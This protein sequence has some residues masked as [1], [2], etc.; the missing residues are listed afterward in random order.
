[1]PVLHETTFADFV[2]TRSP[3]LLYLAY[4]LTRDRGKAEDLL[5]TALAR[6]WPAWD[7]IHSDPEAYVRRIMITTYSAWWRRKW[8]GEVPTDQLPERITADPHSGVDDREEMLAALRRLPRQQRA[9]LVLRYYED[10]SEVDIAEI[11]GISPGTVKSHAQKALASLRLD[12]ALAA[13]TLRPT[14][15]VAPI[16]MSAVTLRVAQR[17]RRRITAIAAACAV[18]TAI[19]LG[20][21]LNPH[22]RTAPPTDPSPRPQ[23]TA[24]YPFA[25]Y[26]SGTRTLDVQE[27][28]PGRTITFRWPPN[29]QK[30]VVLFRCGSEPRLILRLRLRL[31][32]GEPWEDGACSSISAA[33]VGAVITPERQSQAG[34]RPGVPAE[35]SVALSPTA[36]DGSV[37]DPSKRATP[38]PPNSQVTVGFA[39]AV[40]WEEYV[41]PP[42]QALPSLDPVLARMWSK[43]FIASAG[44][45]MQP[46]SATFV[47]SE[48]DLVMVRVGAPVELSVLVAGRP[49]TTCT[50][51][52]N[53]EIAC[54]FDLGPKSR[55]RPGG[56]AP[57]LGSTVTVTVVPVHATEPW[58]LYLTGRAPQP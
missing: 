17:R 47:W 43:P 21:A 22:R 44:D 26:V 13:S 29:G 56:L 16:A 42:K 14:A 10:L 57:A 6:A 50:S 34:L 31:N 55:D 52:A 2:A 36:I 45:P 51:W 53:Q 41:F 12:A 49:F 28:V 38:V 30:L 15:S 4:L 39:I 20:Y 48:T 25:E 54:S 5:Q 3:R 23:S 1:M 46:R 7:R 35:L 40:P 33:Q 18:V 27:L 9:V 24:F 37:K 11:L 32:G 19:I 8:N 58:A